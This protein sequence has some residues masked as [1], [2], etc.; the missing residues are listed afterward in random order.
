MERLPTGKF[1]TNVLVLTCAGFACNIL[2][3]IGQLG[4]CG[5][6]SPVRHLAKCRII[7]TVIQEIMTIAARLVRSARQ[8]TLFLTT[9]TGLRGVFKGLRRPFAQLTGRKKPHSEP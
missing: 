5:H 8:L 9:L 6:N 1:A 3:F 7:R 2:R 4:L